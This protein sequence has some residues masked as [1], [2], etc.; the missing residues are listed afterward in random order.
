[1][2]QHQ[3]KRH[4]VRYD[5]RYCS[6]VLHEWKGV[7]SKVHQLEVLVGWRKHELE[8]AGLKAILSRWGTFSRVKT[9]AGLMNLEHLRGAFSAMKFGLVED[10]SR[11]K[12]KQ[13]AAKHRLLT[14]FRS[15]QRALDQIRSHEAMV[16]KMQTM[17]AAVNGAARKE[18]DGVEEKYLLAL[19][20]VEQRN[21]RQKSSLTRVLKKL[22]STETLHRMRRVF[23]VW[24]TRSLHSREAVH[25]IQRRHKD[26][27]A[28]ILSTC[29]NTFRKRTVG[30]R[31]LSQR[32][33]E[34]WV[35]ET[36]DW[37]FSCW[38]NFVTAS[39]CTALQ[40]DLQEAHDY[41]SN[42]E[43]ERNS[44]LLMVGDC[45]DTHHQL[46]DAYHHLS[47]EREHMLTKPKKTVPKKGRKG[48]RYE[49]VVA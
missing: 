47:A 24:H 18:M 31:R 9:M 29:I 14:A 8:L 13:R 49:G 37:V 12:K 6:G 38:C 33:R 3:S 42:L 40:Q 26:R 20:E 15:F 39:Y 41:N 10:R 11:D 44:L 22:V 45:M 5:R 34:T 32:R 30:L 23:S 35:W 1:M 25:R 2:S 21:A 7:I 36:Q 17:L 16:K 48:K 19:K 46:S 43:E 27:E 28:S 4:A